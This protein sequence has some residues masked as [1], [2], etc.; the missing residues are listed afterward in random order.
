[1]Q[2]ACDWPR[3]T[4]IFSRNAGPIICAFCAVQEGETYEEDGGGWEALA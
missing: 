1:M 3:G 4:N 2:S